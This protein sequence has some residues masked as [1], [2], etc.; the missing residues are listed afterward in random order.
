MEP[1][2]PTR[3]RTLQPAG[4]VMRRNRRAR[5]QDTN[6]ARNAMTRTGDSPRRHAPRATRSKRRGRTRRSRAGARRATARTVPTAFRRPLRARAVMHRRRCPRCMRSRVTPHVAAATRRRTSRRTEIAPR[7]RAAAT[8]TS[9]TITPK[10]WCAQVVMCSDDRGAR[11]GR[12]HRAD[13]T[14]PSI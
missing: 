7:A 12:P 9:A 1:R 4:P 13:S 6:V 14:T 8:P 11:E 2:S 10:P 3:R 5:P